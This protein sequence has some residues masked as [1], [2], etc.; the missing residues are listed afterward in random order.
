M[1]PATTSWSK[2]TPL[3]ALSCRSTFSVLFGTFFSFTRP[4]SIVMHLALW[5]GSPAGAWLALRQQGLGGPGRTA[6]A[7]LIFHGVALGSAVLVS[8]LGFGNRPLIFYKLQAGLVL[9]AL[10]VIV[11][12]LARGYV[13]WRG[14]AAQP[15][16][17]PSGAH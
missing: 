15:A 11:P 1:K 16:P 2:V 8:L 6:I 13:V 14:G 7:I 17:A 3:K 12:L 4:F 10:L 9:I 5:A